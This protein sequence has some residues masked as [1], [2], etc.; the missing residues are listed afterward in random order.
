M[1]HLVDA[2]PPGSVNLTPDLDPITEPA[3]LRRSDGRERL[4]AHRRAT[5]SPAPRSSTP[6]SAS[7]TPPA[8]TAAPGSDPVDVELALLAAT[9]DGDRR[10]TAA[11]SDAGAAPWPTSGAR[12][13]LALAPAGRG[14][15][16]RC[17]VLA[18]R[19]DRRVGHEAVGLAPSAAA[20]AVLA[21]A[22][23]MPC[24][25]LAK[26]VHDPRH[27]GNSIA[28]RIG[29]GTLVVIDEAGMADT[30]TLRP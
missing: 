2:V 8:P 28:G 26:L 10:S 18:R 19:V 30:L 12:V 5:T 11:S 21:E 9:L 17:S 14:R 6:S 25:T 22:T 13:Q 29:P 20:A 27:A 24:E 16:P 23:G 15:R 4:P 7:S 3:A 1:E